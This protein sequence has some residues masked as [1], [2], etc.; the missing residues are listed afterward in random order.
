MSNPRPQKLYGAVRTALVGYGVAALAFLG[1]RAAPA[2]TPASGESGISLVLWGIGI[3]LALM[4]AR[5]LIKRRVADQ[6][7]DK[8]LLVLELIG[9]GATVLL[10]ALGTFG[11]IFARLDNI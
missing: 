7:A 9:D 2:G 6:A 10:F 5:A 1:S 3:Q 11:T 4:A 8:L